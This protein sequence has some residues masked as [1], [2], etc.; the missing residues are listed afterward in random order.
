MKWAITV[1]LA[2]I[3]VVLF[4][5]SWNQARERDERLRREAAAELARQKEQAEIEESRRRKKE[6]AQQAAEDEKELDKKLKETF[7]Y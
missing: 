2:L 4:G 3:L 7:G 6:A 1:L 5:I